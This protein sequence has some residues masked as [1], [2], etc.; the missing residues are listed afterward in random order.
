MAN[1]EWLYDRAKAFG[2]PV[3]A[4]IM[5][6]D[7]C[8]FLLCRIA[9]KRY[10]SL[11]DSDYN[12]LCH[13]IGSTLLNS[14]DNIGLAASQRV[15]DAIRMLLAQK[16]PKNTVILAAYR[17]AGDDLRCA[18]IETIVAEEVSHY[19]KHKKP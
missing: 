18:E 7:E 9:L 12:R 5:H 10:P 4:G 14:A 6:F 17:A 3:R 1:P 8:Y 13:N 11:S 16:K 19:V 2:E 15:R